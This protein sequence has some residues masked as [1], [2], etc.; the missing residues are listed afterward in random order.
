MA[1]TTWLEVRHAERADAS[2]QDDLLVLVAVS[3]QRVL[4]AAALAVVPYFE[5]PGCWGYADRCAVRPLLQGP[6]F[7][8]PRPCPD[9]LM[10][11]D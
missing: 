4:G 9:G 1:A 6:G 5:Q 7:H 8:D 3:G 10:R 11:T 2:A